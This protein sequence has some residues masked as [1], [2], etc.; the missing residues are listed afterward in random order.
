MD[1]KLRIPETNTKYYYLKSVH[2][3]M[4]TNNKQTYNVK[5]T[6]CMVHS[7]LFHVPGRAKYCTNEDYMRQN[8]TVHQMNDPQINVTV[9]LF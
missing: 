7:S 4:Y 5:K 3:T 8:G 9:R 2:S 1:F 6:E